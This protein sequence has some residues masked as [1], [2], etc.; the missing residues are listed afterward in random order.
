MSDIRYFVSLLVACLGRRIKPL[1]LSAAAAEAGPSVER[2]VELT[3]EGSVKDVLRN[4]AVP[5]QHLVG[6]DAGDDGQKGRMV[7]SL[8]GHAVARKEAD[9]HRERRRGSARVER[10]G[11]LTLAWQRG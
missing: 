2:D 6:M 11:R 1:L 10:T 7:K 5:H 3:G 4:E 8:R 9:L